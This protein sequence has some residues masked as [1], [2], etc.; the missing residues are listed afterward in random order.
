VPGADD[1]VRLKSIFPE[2]V[3]DYG[4]PDQARP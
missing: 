1:V 3:C 2:G 4:K